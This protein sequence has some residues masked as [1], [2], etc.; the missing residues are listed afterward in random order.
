MN[1]FYRAFKTVLLL[2]F[3]FIALSQVQVSFPTSRAVFQRDKANQATIRITGY[4][5]STVTRI[6]ARLQARDGQGASIDWRTIQ[7]NVTGGVYAGDLTSQAGWYNLEVRGMNGNQQVGNVATTERVGIGEVFIIAGQ[8]NAQGVHQSAP[9]PSNDRV[10][11]VN[12]QYPGD[13]YPNDPPTPVFTQLDNSPG[14]TISPR[15]TGSW[16]W[17]QLGDLLVKRLNVPVMF[18]NGAFSGTPV[19]N[20]RQSAPEGGT[21]YSVYNG[22]PY[23]PRQPYINLKLA[24]QFYANVL[25]VRAVL[26]HQG[27]ADNLLNTSTSQ[28]VSD[29]QFVINQT[30]QDYNRN[31]SWVVS[32]ATYGDNIG[33]VDP[34]IIAAQDIVINSTGNVFA[35]PN[36]DGIQVPRKR[37]PLFDVDAIHFDYDGLLEVANAWNNSLNDS[38][39]QNSNPVSPAPTPTLSVACAGNNSLRISVNGNYS[40]VQWSSGEMGNTITKSG[41]IYRAKIKDNLGNTFFSAQVSVPNVTATVAN[42]GLPFVC[43]GNSLSL[44][45]N[46]DANVTWVN[47]QTNAV[48]GNGPT[49]S[50]SVEGNFYVR[51]RDVSGCDFTSNVINATIKPLPS[52]PAISNDKPTTFCQGDNTVL[53][54]STDITRYNWSDGQ[55][56]K[57]VTISN[58]GSYFL[59]VTDQFGCTSA[60]SNTI[61]VTANPVPVKPVIATNGP[62]TFCADRNIT[63]TAPQNVAYQWT[64]G[65]TTQSITINESGNFAVVTRN[66]FGCSSVQSDITTIKVNPLPASPSISAGGAT[67]FCDGNRV[68]LTAASPLDVIWSSGQNAKSIVVTSSGNYAVQ[69]RDQIG[70]LS[71]YSTVITVRVNPL[72]PTPTILANPDRII[73]EEDKVTLRVEGPY[74]VFWSTGDSTQRIVTGAAGIY[75]AKV[76]DVNGCISAQAGS[77]TVELRPL[78]APPTINIIGTYTLEA[79]SSANGNQFRWY[80]GTDSL[81]FQSSIIKANQSGLYTARSSTVYS[82][83]LT[84][85]SRPSTPISFT[86]DLSNRGL[87]IYPNPNPNKVIIL[88]T[89]EN[90]ANATVT[91]FTLYGQQVFATTVPLFDERKQFVLT[92][93]PSGPYILRVQAAS[94]NVSKRIILGL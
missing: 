61:S 56:G 22:Q 30:R 82:P 10:N 9:N 31:M 91:L 17:G 63:L 24:L 66:Q 86:V 84:C 83:I 39:F 49:F 90:L 2:L 25:G 62:T 46:F 58:S 93:L 41:G 94:F 34:A 29:L 59:T 55:Q 53:R 54:T 18:F 87:S 81:A 71:P 42:N 37:P 38:F 60:Q 68:T 47:Q 19:Q 23:P 75:S 77:T 44:V 20:W 36:T 11:C 14:F 48:V 13:G 73:C 33:G 32:R 28:Y 72:P 88:E 40:N 67:T 16:C 57:S 12:Y 6:E 78:P 4:Y 80:R 26:W 79:V 8:S 52:T 74:T 27:E 70:C 85:F 5:T 43:A 89:L 45:A 64:S 3:P 69:A 1:H 21:A 76:R 35:G 65:Q 15:G 92:G 50:T 7:D 51:Y